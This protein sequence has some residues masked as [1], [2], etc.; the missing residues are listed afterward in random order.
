MKLRKLLNYSEPLGDFMAFVP[1]ERRQ[2][3]WP[4]T[5]AYLARLVIHRYAMLGVLDENGGRTSEMGILEGA[6]FRGMRTLGSSPAAL[7]GVRQPDPY[8]PRR[9]RRLH[10]LLRLRRSL[11]L[12][13]MLQDMQR[14]GVRCVA[15]LLS[16]AILCAARRPGRRTR[17]QRRRRRRRRR[18]PA[19]AAEP[20][21]RALDRRLR[22]DARAAGHPR[23]R[24]L[25]PHAL[26]RRQGARARHHGG[27]RARL[28]GLRQQAVREAAR[29]AP[30]DG[31]TSSRPRATG[32][33]PGWRRGPGRHRGRQP[34]GDRGAAEARRFRGAHGS[35][36]GARADRDRAGAPRD[37]DARRSLRQDGA[38]APDERAIT[39]AWSP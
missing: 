9:L 38:R 7:P 12:H 39:R 10:R 34:H 4:S 14:Y 26:L 24:A 28:R 35:Q 8:P 36:A 11:R 37:R 2:Q 13:G 3:N 19:P 33:S 1:G 15:A 27:A 16:A 20:P 22:P 30:G 29:Q 17:R 5:V 31:H 18:R 32:C 23:A 21:E 25:Q 6:R